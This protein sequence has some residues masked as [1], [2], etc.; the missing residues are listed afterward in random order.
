VVLVQQTGDLA[1]ADQ[2]G[3]KI[4]GGVAAELRKNVNH[5]LIR[6]SGVVPK[7]K[8]LNIRFGNHSICRDMELARNFLTAAAT[9][10]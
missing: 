5:L 2:C 10:S 3:R 4:F 9:S 1:T 6:R 8:R 7:P